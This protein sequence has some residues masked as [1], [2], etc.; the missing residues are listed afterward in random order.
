MKEFLACAVPLSEPC[1][2]ACDIVQIQKCMSPFDEEFRVSRFLEAESRVTVNI[3]IVGGTGHWDLMG[4][5]LQVTVM[6]RI[7][8]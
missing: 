5:E 4:T 1:C 6:K 2:H 7:L 3:S 8:V